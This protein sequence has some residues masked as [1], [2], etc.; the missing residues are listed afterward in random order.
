MNNVKVKYSFAEWCR[1]NNHQDWLD[2][3][4]YELNETKPEEVAYRS[5]K[6]HWFKCPVGLHKSEY[7]ILSDLCIRK[8]PFICKQCNSLGQHLINTFGDGAIEKYWSEKNDINPFYVAKFSNKKYFF[9]CPDC[10]NIKYTNVYDWVINPFSC[11]KCGDG[12]SYPN[13]FMREFLLQL[14]AIH[15]FKVLPEHV[16]SWS[17]NIDVN[18]KRRIYDFVINEDNSIIIEVH[19]IQHY[20]HGFCD[21][22][23]GKTLDEELSNDA[24]KKALALRNG[25][26]PQNYIVIDARYSKPEWIKNSI[27]QSELSRIYNF[28]ESDI[29]WVK[30]NEVACKSAVRTVCD[31]YTSG[32]TSVMELSRQTGYC[33]KTIHKY[34]KLGVANNWCNYSEEYRRCS[35]MH[36]LQCVENGYV[37]ASRS[38]CAKVS[39]DLFGEKLSAWN[40]GSHIISQKPTSK[41][42]HFTDITKEYFIDAQSNNPAIVFGILH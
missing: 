34:L 26:R 13:K 35:G 16:F 37:F 23:G 39:E 10:G 33:K 6:R 20:E 14:E 42:W 4:D 40:I 22:D 27:L 11:K 2:R 8:T 30:C 17:E 41:G 3:W 15:K 18:T 29:D 1:D 28:S 9:K 12:N 31:L 5:N 7:T 21:F 32:I 36:P 38:A 19:G 25:I 24:F